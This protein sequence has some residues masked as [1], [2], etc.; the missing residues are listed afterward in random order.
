MRNVL[1]G[2]IPGRFRAELYAHL[3]VAEQPDRTRTRDDR[4]HTPG[5]EA[6]TPA[7]EAHPDRGSDPRTP[8]P[9]ESTPPRTVRL[10]DREVDQP[11][12]GYRLSIH[13]GSRRSS[14]FEAATARFRSDSVLT[15]VVAIAMS[16][17]FVI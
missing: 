16:C 11:T 13:D 3:R 6:Q 7:P 12:S 5:S 1:F 10:R 14:S 2:L 4:L 8:G 15:F 17:F 9:I